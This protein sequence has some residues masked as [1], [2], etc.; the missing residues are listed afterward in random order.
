[1]RSSV[2]A[3]YASGLFNLMRNLGGAIGIAL[4]NTWLQDATRLHVLRLSEGLGASGDAAG[5]AA[6][7]LTQS[8]GQFVTDPHRA[9]LMAD[10]LLARIVGRQALGLAFEDVF[11]MMSYLFIAALLMVPFCRPPTVLGPPPAEH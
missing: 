10:A 11:R 9:T 8:I 5:E 3:G 6:A 2:S 4:A 7:Q 1:M